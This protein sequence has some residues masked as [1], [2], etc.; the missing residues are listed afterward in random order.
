MNVAVVG[1]G[2][3]GGSLAKTIQKHTDY[4]V[5]G[6]DK[7]EDVLN[8]ALS[9]GAIDTAGSA[10]DLSEAD[11]TIICLYPEIIPTFVEENKMNFKENSVI[12]D[13]AGIKSK[14]CSEISGIDLGNTVFV[15][16][17]P[18]AGREVSGFE[19]S[20]DNLFDNASF[21]FTPI[22]VDEEIVENLKKFALDIGFKTTVVT[23]PEKHDSIIAYTSQIAHVLACAYV[24][25]PNSRN[26]FGFSAGSFK[27]VSRVAKINEELW[28]QL[29][30]DNSETLCREIDI[31]IENLSSMRDMIASGDGHKLKAT[32]RK[33]REIKEELDK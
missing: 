16:A 30:L 26:H 12:I 9:S 1:L 21:I 5:I 4:K 31:L 20:V 18:M 14:I 25:S 19:N 23:T 10:K 11:I 15:G 24:L 6:I 33:G 8:K 3:I 7:N 29:F 32:L 22:G 17:H 13:T 2:L 27:D 28:T